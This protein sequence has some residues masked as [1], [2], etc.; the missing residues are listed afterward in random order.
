MG[1][2]WLHVV[3]H[4]TRPPGN[5]QTR[6]RSGTMI[7][8][9]KQII[10]TLIDDVDGKKADETLTFALDGTNYEIDLSE[11]NARKMRETLGPWMQS[12]R[13]V[14]GQ[15][16]PS[17]RRSSTAASIPAG[18]RKRYLTQVREWALANGIDVSARG[19]I[20]ADVIRR[21]DEAS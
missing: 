20:P 1:A 5:V 16:R 14:K 21:Y 12:A 13:R 6:S 9:A 15:S 17:S 18:N 4:V 3:G 11:K 8:M 7:G 19:R 2:G 10:T